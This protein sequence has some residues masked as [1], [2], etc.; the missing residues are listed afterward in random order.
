VTPFQLAVISSGFSL[1]GVVFGSVLTYWCAVKLARRNARRDAGRR[2]R[3]AFLPELA[4]L[5]PVTGSTT[6]VEH[7]LREA[8]PRHH[9]AVAE[10][11]FHLSPNKRAALETAWRQY[12]EVGRSI[13]FFDYHSGDSPYDK[14]KERVGAI[15]EFTET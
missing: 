11:M 6:D 7:L 10:L 8:W 15:L 1:L 14:F 9:A 3:E 12:Y 2:L 4:A 5:D 13:R